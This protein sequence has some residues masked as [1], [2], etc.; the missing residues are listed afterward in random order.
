MNIRAEEE[1]DYMRFEPFDPGRK[2]RGCISV[3][4]IL[5]QL[6]GDHLKVIC[7]LLE[8]PLILNRHLLAPEEANQRHC[9]IFSCK[10]SH[11]NRF[12]HIRGTLEDTFHQ[13]SWQ[14]LRR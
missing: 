14:D 10:A 2:V 5:F 3:V 9:N 7:H 12:H 6:P 13:A 11:F 1:W 4:R 8:S